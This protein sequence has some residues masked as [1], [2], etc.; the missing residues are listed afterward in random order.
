MFVATKWRSSNSSHQGQDLFWILR[1]YCGRPARPKRSWHQTLWLTLTLLLDAMQAWPGKKIQKELN[2]SENSNTRVA[3]TGQAHTKEAKS[4][5]C[6]V[7]TISSKL[8]L[9]VKYGIFCS[10]PPGTQVVHVFVQEKDKQYPT[11]AVSGSTSIWAGFTTLAKS[12]WRLVMGR[13]MIASI[14]S[15]SNQRFKDFDHLKAGCQPHTLHAVK[16]FHRHQK[17]WGLNRQP[18]EVVNVVLS[19]ISFYLFLFVSACALRLLMFV[20]CHLSQATQISAWP[21]CFS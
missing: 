13:P 1:N 16:M 11:F 6:S 4:N 10:I 5:W 19:W 21:W 2:H 9:K 14:S 18:L 3:E 20:P 8:N 17:V 12:A 7:H 15:G